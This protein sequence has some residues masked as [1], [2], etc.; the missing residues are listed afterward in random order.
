[1]EN[2]V[3]EVLGEMVK[4]GGF[5]KSMKDSQA[6]IHGGWQSTHRTHTKERAPNDFTDSRLNTQDRQ[7]ILKSAGV[8]LHT[9]R[10]H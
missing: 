4:P 10:G 9:R 2:G 6:Q 3:Q 5:L 8:L 1:M 7:S